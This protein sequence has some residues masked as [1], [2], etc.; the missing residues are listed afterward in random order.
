V[1]RSGAVTL[2]D[3]IDPTLT[4]VCK[5]CARKGVY[6]VARL[7]A[8]HG[9]AKLPDLRAYLS[10]IARSKSWARPQI[11][12]RRCSARPIRGAQARPL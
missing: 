4:L 12:A 8:K 9:D 5:P 10:A 3:V 2:S 1:P 7:M 11:D 6:S